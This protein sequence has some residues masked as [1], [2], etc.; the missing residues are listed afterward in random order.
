MREKAAFYGQKK[1]S[2]EGEENLS[3]CSGRPAGTLPSHL[4]PVLILYLFF[5]GWFNVMEAF[6]ESQADAFFDETV[7]VLYDMSKTRI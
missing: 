1:C 6:D 2:I 5:P 3:G 4:P 7:G